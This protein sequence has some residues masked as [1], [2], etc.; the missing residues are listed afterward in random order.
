MIDWEKENHQAKRQF[1]SYYCS[2][3]K[4]KKPCQLFDREYCCSC[5]YHQEREKAGEYSSYEKVLEDKQKEQEAKIKQ[6]KLLREYSGC[7]QC[8]SK[9]VDAF[10][11]YENNK[12]ICHPCLMKKEGGASSPISF[13][14]QQKWYK[15]HWKIELSE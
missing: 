15:K 2:A 6:L 3:C 4:Q 9:Q 10:E 14:E 11:L 7:S 1:R 8:E 13:L 12:L 5:Y